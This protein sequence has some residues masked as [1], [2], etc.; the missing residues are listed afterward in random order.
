MTDEYLLLVAKVLRVFSS[1]GQIS[2]I[3]LYILFVSFGL[4]HYEFQRASLFPGN[5]S[6]IES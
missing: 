3:L 6:K 4:Y 1:Y 5:T 2:N